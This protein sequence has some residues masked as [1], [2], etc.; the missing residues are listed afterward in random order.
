MMLLETFVC[1]GLLRTHPGF[2]LRRMGGVGLWG[3]HSGS[4]TEEREDPFFFP[5]CYFIFSLSLFHLR[6]QHAVPV[7]L[8]LGEQIRL[9]RERHR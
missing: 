6:P 8:G 1:T 4:E 5:S 3:S 2:V 9:Q 7:E